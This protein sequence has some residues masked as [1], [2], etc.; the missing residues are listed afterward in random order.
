M[1]DTSV[2]KILMSNGFSTP[3]K[4]Q[5]CESQNLC[6]PDKTL[7]MGNIDE[8][9]G[10]EFIMEAYDKFG[11]QVHKVKLVNEKESEKRASY[12]F[13]EFGSESDAQN[14]MLQVNGRTILNDPD[15]RRFQLSFV[16]S[17]EIHEALVQQL[18]VFMAVPVQ[19]PIST[20]LPAQFP[21]Q[22]QPYESQ[23]LCPPEKTLW[24]GNI[25]RSWEPEF[26]M[27][28]FEK[29]GFQVHRVKLVTEK[30]SD[31]RA[32]YCFVEF[33]SEEDAQNVMLQVNGRTILNDPDKR[34]FHLS[35]ANSPTP[36]MEFNLFVDN[37][38]HTVDDVKLYR[39]FGERYKSCRGAKVYKTHDGLSKGSGFVR[40][41]SETD[42][43]AALVEMNNTEV[44]GKK[45]TL[46]LSY[47]MHKGHAPRFSRGGFSNGIHRS[48]S[49]H[50]MY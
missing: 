31:N 39:V 46:K 44:R 17:P 41:K 42:Q 47:P 43:Q 22:D 35:F 10:P 23:H 37:L 27:E 3:I 33:G 30:G 25:E 48:Y 36:H 21:I 24:M 4:G 14:V 12:C 28:A 11:F 15:Q 19:A 49:S 5:Q 13:V 2:Q 1:D 9:W 29:F 45:I 32:S 20:N 16:D 18:P 38:S 50:V 8:T 34:R 40:F 6:S 26:I 7:L